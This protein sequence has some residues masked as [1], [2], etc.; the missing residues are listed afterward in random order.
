MGRPLLLVVLLLD[1]LEDEVSLA[2]RE[3]L[4]LLAVAMPQALLIDGGLAKGQKACFFEQVDAVFTGF[5]GLGFC[6]H[7]DSWRVELDVGWDDSFC[8][9]DE[10]EQGEPGRPVWRCSETPEDGRQLVKLAAR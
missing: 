3:G 4:D 8:S 9:I 6:V 10:E 1:K 5:L 2:E 7:Y